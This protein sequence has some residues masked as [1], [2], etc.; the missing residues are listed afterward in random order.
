ML[1]TIFTDGSYNHHNTTGGWAVYVDTDKGRL[2]HYGACPD[3]VSCSN[4][5][6][7]FAIYMGV[8]L[9]FREWGEEIHAFKIRS[10]SECALRH[11]KKGPLKSRVRDREMLKVRSWIHD[12]FRKCGAQVITEHVKGHQDPS[13]SYDFAMNNKVDRMASM[14]RKSVKGAGYLK[15]SEALEIGQDE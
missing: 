15:V 8:S 2:V 9:A 14:G 7:I 12:L 11:V 3:F 6:E 1:A 5:A 13:L 4:H 10:D